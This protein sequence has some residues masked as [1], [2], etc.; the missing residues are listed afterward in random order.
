[1]VAFIIED[2]KAYYDV[3]VIQKGQIYSINLRF[4]LICLLI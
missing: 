4:D 3:I 1:M 2:E